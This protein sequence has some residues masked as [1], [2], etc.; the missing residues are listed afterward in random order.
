M[1]LGIEAV[2]MARPLTK[3]L[4]V[5]FSFYL[6]PVCRLIVVHL[7]IENFYYVSCWKLNPS[8]FSKGFSSLD[9]I[10]YYSNPSKGLLSKLCVS[11]FQHFEVRLYEEDDF[12]ARSRC[13]VTGRVCQCPRSI[14]GPCYPSSQWT[15]EDWG[16]NGQWVMF[17]LNGSAVALSRLSVDT[18]TRQSDWHLDWQTHTHRCTYISPSFWQALPSHHWAVL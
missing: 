2:R 6:S 17:L 4:Y 9:L 11:T 14:C 1:H 10:K 3:T 15:G 16:L 8:G 7:S 5:G 18:M 12:P 13:S